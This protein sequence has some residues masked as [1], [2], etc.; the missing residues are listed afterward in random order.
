MHNW[1]INAWILIK[2]FKLKFNWL[3]N[4][5]KLEF[6]FLKKESS[7]WIQLQQFFH[8]KSDGRKQFRQI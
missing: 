6:Y 2:D 5:T 8:G 3:K 1:Y 7:T 4:S